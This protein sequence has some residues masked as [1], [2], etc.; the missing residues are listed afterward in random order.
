V[1]RRLGGAVGAAIDQV[2]PLPHRRAAAGFDDMLDR[3]EAQRPGS[4]L[5]G[6]DIGDARHPPHGVPYPQLAVEGDAAAGPHPAWQRHRRQ[7]ASP[8][9]M[10][11]RPQR[12]CRRGGLR[13]AEMDQPRRRV[14]GPGR[15]ARQVQR[16]LE[17]A[18]E[19]GG[20]DILRRILAADPAAQMVDVEP[21][22]GHRPRVLM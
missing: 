4:A 8:F 10:A 14:A 5:L 19:V 3:D 7:E 2:L 17:L 1:T 12:G 15:R 11:V 16:G 6:H 9:R 22:H 13:Q 20:D 18:D 21:R